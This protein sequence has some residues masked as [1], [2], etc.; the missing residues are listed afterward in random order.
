MLRLHKIRRQQ[1]RVSKFK[2]QKI[3]FLFVGLLFDDCLRV[4]VL[5]TPVYEWEIN[6]EE[7]KIAID[8]EVILVIIIVMAVQ[9]IFMKLFFLVRRS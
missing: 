4:N 9:Y 1:I 7:S 6:R 5:R 3:R 2:R 8:G